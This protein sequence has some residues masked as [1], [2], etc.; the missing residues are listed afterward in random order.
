M[1]Q[2][3]YLNAS[4]LSYSNQHR[5]FLDHPEIQR[6]LYSESP[7]YVYFKL[8]D[9][10]PLGIQSIP[11]TENRS[12][13]YD[14]AY[15]PASG[16]LSFVALTVNGKEITRFMLGQDVGGAIKGSARADLYFGFG[17]DARIAAESLGALGKQ[18]FLIKRENGKNLFK[19][20]PASN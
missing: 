9:E 15:H 10:E 17:E 6:Q 11:L 12:L 14:P 18:F 3:G 20:H 7:S 8:S 4:N 5:Y 13:A 2:H 19:G 1:V 16:V